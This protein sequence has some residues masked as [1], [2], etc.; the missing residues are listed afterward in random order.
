M[1]SGFAHPLSFSSS[2]MS[3]LISLSEAHLLIIC[4]ISSSVTFCVQA[5]ACGNSELLVGFL[6]TTGCA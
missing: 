1:V 4:W 6:L 2:E 5:L 3:I